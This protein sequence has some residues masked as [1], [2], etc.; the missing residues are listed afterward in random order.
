M[1]SVAHGTPGSCLRVVQ[2][3]RGE[4]LDERTFFQPAR[5]TLGGGTGSTFVIPDLG[6]GDAYCLL[7][8]RGRNWVLELAQGMAGEL[9]Q[10]GTTRPVADWSPAPDAASSPVS[11]EVGDWGIVHVDGAGEHTFYFHL[12]PVARKLGQGPWRDLEDLVPAT[13]I[14]I[15]LVGLFLVMSLI[16]HQP[17]SSGRPGAG[18]DS[19]AHYLVHR[20]KAAPPA[21]ELPSKDKMAGV[22]KGDE[23]AKPT[24]A[25][26]KAGKGGGA[27]DSARAR[28]TREG[29]VLPSS[30]DALLRAVE[31]RG[32]LKHRAELAAIGGRG[33]LDDRLG[34]ATARLQGSNLAGGA[35]SGLGTGLGVGL[36]AGS[37]TLTRGGEGGPG[38]GGT[39][40]DDVV[41]KETIETGGSRAA[42]GVPRGRQVAEVKV[43]AGAEGLEGDFGDLSKE[44]IQKVVL[45]HKNAVS[46]CYEK[47]LQSDPGLKG[48]IVVNFRL[49][50]TGTVTS[51][52]T[53]SST[54]NNPSVE[55]CVVRQVRKW[56]FPPGSEAVVN[57][58]FVFASR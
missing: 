50:D 58:P 11:L 34:L 51:S 53:K 4:I 17:A 19:L 30:R 36:G 25:S 21:P 49:D 13:L 31:N 9:C 52:K 55:D 35:G 44:Q 48:T 18:S 40:H 12:Q 47:E 57:Y 10:R 6:L 26:G 38:G 24:A 22:E 14:A 42:K 15:F 29:D 2:I 16:V 43:T 56:K 33:A 41:T 27:G 37:G 7:G 32:I 45:A 46:Y 23:K 5:V 39:A 28:T 8:P 1:T 54:M 3:W 20:P